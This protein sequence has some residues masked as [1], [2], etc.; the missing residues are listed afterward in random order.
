MTCS[1]LYNLGMYMWD[2]LQGIWYSL[3]QLKDQ[4]SA[5]SSTSP[6]MQENAQEGAWRWWSPFADKEARSPHTSW[7]SPT[8]PASLDWNLKKSQ[9]LTAAP[10]A[11]S[12][13]AM[14]HASHGGRKGRAAT[15]NPTQSQRAE[16]V[17]RSGSPEARPY[18]TQ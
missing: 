15:E 7:A 8:T 18:R 9:T 2:T 4:V 10:A 11:G 12:E 6:K 13:S 16:H 14:A 3:G 17:L 5:A 1:I